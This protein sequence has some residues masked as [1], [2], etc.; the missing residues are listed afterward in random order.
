METIGEIADKMFDKLKDSVHFHAAS[1]FVRV[2]GVVWR[3]EIRKG[4]Q[5]CLE[6]GLRKNKCCCRSD[7]D[8]A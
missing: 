4:D 2:D 1:E 5:F 8:D 3:I 7:D 6:C